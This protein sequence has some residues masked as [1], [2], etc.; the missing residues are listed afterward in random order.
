MYY[1]YK[2]NT[3]PPYAYTLLPV[4]RYLSFRVIGKSQ[5]S[6]RDLGK[7]AYKLFPARSAKE[8]NEI[9]HQYSRGDGPD[10]EDIKMLQLG[11]LRLK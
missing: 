11:L 6:L 1:K 8:E 3:V 5:D 9:L 7:S 4:R 2:Y 10:W